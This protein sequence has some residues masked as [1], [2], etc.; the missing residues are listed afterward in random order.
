MPLVFEGGLR[1]LSEIS[2]ARD[3]AKLGKSART[4]AQLMDA[5]I[6]VIASC[7]VEGATVNE[8][9]RKAGVANGTFYS[10][11][12]DKDEI[13]SVVSGAIALEIAK[14]LN[15]LMSDID[16]A[17]TRVATGTRLFMDI[18]CQTPDL[19]WALMKAFYSIPELRLQVGAYMR[20][21]ISK[22]VKQGTFLE[23]TDDFLMDCIGGLVGSALVS[24]LTGRVGP[25]A[26]IRAAE[27]QLQLLGVDAKTAKQAASQPLDLQ[28]PQT[29]E[30]LD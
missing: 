29:A 4:R 2:F 20:S 13:V 30:L 16:C 19:G 10:H 1:L 11:F 22:G 6:A 15:D 7:N 25:E 5:A 26:G 9:T 28:P 8:I 23:T 18:A 17:I 14:Q 27:L 21:D 24:R 12:K 3:A